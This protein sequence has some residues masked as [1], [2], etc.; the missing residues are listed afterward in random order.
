M[1]PGFG[2]QVDLTV[3]IGQCW[4]FITLVHGE[5]RRHN[6]SYLDLF[7]KENDESGMD[8][9]EL[10]SAWQRKIFFLSSLPIVGPAMVTGSS[11]L[12]IHQLLVDFREL[13]VDRENSKV[14][15]AQTDNLIETLHEKPELLKYLTPETKGRILY[16][17][18]SVPI[19]WSERLSNWSSLDFLGG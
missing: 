7:E 1:G 6:F 18:L 2:G 19:D 17:L 15:Q 13:L 10:F 12:K 4:D 14:I 5:L 11:A 8:V 3:G 16:G 9:F